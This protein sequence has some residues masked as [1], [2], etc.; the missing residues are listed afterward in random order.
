[1]F[2]VECEVYKRQCYITT[3]FG[4]ILNFAVGLGCHP[5]YQNVGLYTSNYAASVI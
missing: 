2:A 3:V 4:R 1:M 5:D